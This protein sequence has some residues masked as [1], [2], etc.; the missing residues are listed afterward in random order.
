[1]KGEQTLAGLST[2][3]TAG[4]PTSKVCFWMLFL[5]ATLAFI[6]CE[7]SLIS[8]FVDHLPFPAEDQ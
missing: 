8:S 2:E 4:V 6:K 7:G 3:R 5:I 1:M